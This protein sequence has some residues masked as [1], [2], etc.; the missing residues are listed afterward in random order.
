MKGK[1]M[2]DKTLACIEAIDRVITLLQELDDG[3]YTYDR[4]I[5]DLED[6]RRGLITRLE[7]DA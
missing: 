4:D 5:N 7:N 3:T 2:T 1:H 6:I